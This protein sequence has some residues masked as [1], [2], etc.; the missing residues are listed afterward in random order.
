MFW[1]TIKLESLPLAVVI[2][3]VGG[4]KLCLVGHGTCLGLA[5][6]EGAVVQGWRIR[7]QLLGLGGLDVAG[8]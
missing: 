3:L 4:K 7:V 5:V 8:V 2:M 1:L 6:V